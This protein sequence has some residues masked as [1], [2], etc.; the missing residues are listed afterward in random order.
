MAASK[1]SGEAID[2]PVG[3]L[4][5]MSLI[6][7]MGLLFLLGL[8]GTPVVAEARLMAGQVA[9]PSPLRRN[10]TTQ[11]EKN[12]AFAQM[13]GRMTPQERQRLRADVSN[14]G[15]SVYPAA[16]DRF[17]APARR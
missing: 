8:F 14:A 10:A 9:S 3:G 6:R 5:M 2:F 17:P 1:C 11:S 13:R 15:R 12:V 4:N 16:T 7:C